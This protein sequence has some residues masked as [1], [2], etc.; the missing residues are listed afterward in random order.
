M[1]SPLGVSPTDG[2]KPERSKPASASNALAVR[3]KV[4]S[5][6]ASIARG[7]RPLKPTNGHTQFLKRS[8][9]THGA[10][11]HFVV[12]FSPLRPRREQASE[13]SVFAVRSTTANIPCMTA[14]GDRPAT[15]TKSESAR[16]LS[17]RKTIRSSC[18][19]AGSPATVKRHTGHR[20]LLRSLAFV[21][22]CALNRT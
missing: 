12:F 4:K 15:R 5:V 2:R 3:F 1:R 10:G 6:V 9:L 16:D 17:T 19:G 20:Q 14:F 18:R 8:N 21:R 11:A 13:L 22:A 7:I